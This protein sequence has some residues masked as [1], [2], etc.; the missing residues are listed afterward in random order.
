MSVF[1]KLF[2]E[3]GFKKINENN[4]YQQSDSFIKSINLQRKSSGDKY[5]INLGV[6]PIMVG[7][8]PYSNMEIDSSMRFRIHPQ[9]GLPIN[10]IDD[11]EFLKEL[12]NGPINDF[13]ESFVSIDALFSPITTNMIEN[14]DL[15][16]HLKSTTGIMSLSLLCARY[17]VS[18]NEIEKAKEMAAYGLSKVRL[19]GQIKKSFKEILA[20]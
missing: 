7:V 8:K 18:K 5:F 4:V 19:G 6:T 9:D 16:E 2:V 10:T 3:H 11:P 12:L 1:S 15:P 20:L 14:R 17:W 13:F